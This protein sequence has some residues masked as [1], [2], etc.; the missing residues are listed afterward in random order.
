M[1]RMTVRFVFRKLNISKFWF[2]IYGK[3][4]ISTGMFCAG[5]LQGETDACQG[6]SGGPA[7]GLIQGRATLLGITSWGYGCGRPNKPGVYTKVREY[8]KW[9][10][11]T[12]R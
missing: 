7:V 11:D 6:D 5:D 10:K 12:T 4:K 1:D 2:Q 8:F 3:D 9:I